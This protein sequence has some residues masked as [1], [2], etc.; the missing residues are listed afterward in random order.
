V[1][2]L[3]Y[4]EGCPVD[5]RGGMRPRNRRVDVFVLD[6]GVRVIS[7]VGCHPGR[8]ESSRRFLPSAPAKKMPEMPIS[9]GH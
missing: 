9:P 4:G 6:A 3:A 8:L 7:P 1:T 2:T 5:P